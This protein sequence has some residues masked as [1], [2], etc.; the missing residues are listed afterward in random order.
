MR[1][2]YLL[3]F[4]MI[5]S[6]AQAE[7]LS[8]EA[9]WLNR[10]TPPLIKDKKYTEA[11]D[12]LSE[13]LVKDPYAAEL[14]NNLGLNYEGTGQLKKAQQAYGLAERA[15]K[16]PLNRFIAIYNQAQ[17]F[18][19]DKQTDQAIAQYQRA[20]EIN[21]DSREVKTNIELLMQQQQQQQQKGEGGE[22]KKDNP[23]D[24]DGKNQEQ[25]KDFAP[26]KPQ[27]KKY[28]PQNLSEGD[29]KKILEELKNQEKKIRAEFEKKQGG[30]E[31]G[32]DKDW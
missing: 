4:S 31:Q 28:Q 29:V 20:L 8:V 26:N 23:D 6:P 30:K 15:A 5:L 3:I 25:P 10:Q 24:K 2:I 7:T 11:I 12:L 16:T 19:K 22:D 21:P 27:P 32:N 17:L 13:A 18:A 9:W 1:I 14:H